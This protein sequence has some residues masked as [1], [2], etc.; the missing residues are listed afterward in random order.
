[1][2][3]LAFGAH[4]DDMELGAGGYLARLASDGAAVT[5]VVVSVPNRREER[6]SEA[7]EGSRILGANLAVLYRE[8]PLRVEDV[9]MYKLV[10][11]FDSLIAELRPD[12][13]ITHSQRD[14]HWDHRLVHQATVSAVRRTPCDLLT[15]MSSPEMNAQSHS[16]GQCFADVTPT[17]DRK[18]AAISAHATQIP[19]LELES[20]RDLARAM[21][22]LCG[23]PYA[24]AF[25]ALRLRI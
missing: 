8:E 2:R 10:A 7:I 4:P 18:L 22:R 23:V 11:R 25:E 19:K 5:M 9:P 1:M 20:S 6:I 16:I 17:I 13:V 15:F 14:L 12:L 21:G 3:V 24:E